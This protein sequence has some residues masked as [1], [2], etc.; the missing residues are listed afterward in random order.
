MTGLDCAPQR[1][2]AQRYAPPAAL[3]V[4]VDVF[5]RFGNRPER[6]IAEVVA[7]SLLSAGES[8]SLALLLH[9]SEERYGAELT[10][11]PLRPT[12]IA[13]PCT[14]LY[15]TR[16]CIHAAAHHRHARPRVLPRC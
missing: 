2:A 10:Y 12:C 4:T 14:A 7:A 6:P 11:T 3:Q 9:R 5:D 1:H 13:L 8:R 16:A 15:C